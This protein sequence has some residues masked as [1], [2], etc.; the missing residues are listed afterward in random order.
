MQL[1]TP[2]LLFFHTPYS[3]GLAGSSTNEAA[4]LAPE[5]CQNPVG[6]IG[7]QQLQSQADPPDTAALQPQPT[8]IGDSFFGVEIASCL[9][10]PGE[11]GSESEE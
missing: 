3:L 11:P 9:G 2:R 8:A 6:N 5:K 10:I 4:D 1:S 7:Q